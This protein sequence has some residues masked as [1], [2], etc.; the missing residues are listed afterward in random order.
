MKT[1]V[2]LLVL[3]FSLVTASAD[4][5]QPAPKKEKQGKTEKDK[6]PQLD[7]EEELNAQ[8]KY[9][10][11]AVVIGGG[12][13][14]LSV[15]EGFR[16]LDPSQAEKVL[17]AWGNPPGKKT[18]GMLFPTDIGPFEESGWGVVI[19]YDDDG[20]VADNDADSVDY[21]ELL[22][23]MKEEVISGNEERTTQG[24]E[25]IELIGWASPPRYDRAAHK[26][27]W[28]RELKFGD[29]DEN[30]LNYD[31]RVLGRKG[32]LSFNAVASMSQLATIKE[33][34]Q[35]VLGFAQF[36]VG[37]QYSEFNPS[38]DKLAA[39]GIGALIAGKVA[40]KVGL[41]KLLLGG[42][43]ALKKFAVLGLVALVAFLRRLFKLKKDAAPENASTTTLNLE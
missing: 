17:V 36:N 41:F 26:L 24:Y 28:A 16:Y 35:Q 42:L 15:P 31:I 14:T 9:Q 11:G 34:M 4:K 33:Q 32:V 39:Y 22:K 12:I 29:Q 21:A 27:Y 19:S 5:S 20:Y 6:E 43:L 40:A 38:V 3:V 37:N 7:P 2:V 25:P 10:R 30:T 13:A 8:L 23:Q 18:L 1:I